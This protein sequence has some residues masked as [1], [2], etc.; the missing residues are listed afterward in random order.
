VVADSFRN[1]ADEIVAK[2]ETK[3]KVKEAKVKE[4]ARGRADDLCMRVRGKRRSGETS[5]GEIMK[6]IVEEGGKYVI[7]KKANEVVGLPPRTALRVRFGR[8]CHRA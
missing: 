2:V 8:A 7:R 5:V 6:K 1:G 4:G 3:C